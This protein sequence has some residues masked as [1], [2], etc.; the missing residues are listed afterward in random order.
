MEAGTNLAKLGL[1]VSN[2]VRIR[3][4][5]P[6]E[7][8][9]GEIRITDNQRKIVLAEPGKLQGTAEDEYYADYCYAEGE[10]ADLY[11]RSISP[12]V[13]SDAAGF[14]GFVDGVNCAILLFGNSRSGKTY[15][16]E[17]SGKGD[18]QDG[19]IPAVIHG[20]FEG[21][22]A[23]LNEQAQG[24]RFG[25]RG[26][27]R[28]WRH[29]LSMQ[30]IEVVNEQI[31]DLLNPQKLELEV[32]EQGVSEGLG[33]RNLTRKWID[34]EEEALHHFKV[35]QSGRTS[36]RGEFGPMSERATAVYCLELHQVTS[37]MH[38]GQDKPVEEHL[39]SRF[40][41]F[42][43]PGAETLADDPV[44]VRIREG[45]TL[46]NSVLGFGNVV[47]SLSQARDNLHDAEFVD[48]K[49]SVLTS[50]LPDVLGGNCRTSIVTTI[51]PA[52]YK[53]NSFTLQFAQLFRQLRNYPVVNDGRQVAL[54]RKVSNQ[55]HLMKQQIA[56]SKGRGLDVDSTFTDNLMEIHRLE[57]KII[58]D[59]NVR[60]ALLEE[61]EQL[62]ERVAQINARV[63]SLL[64]EK[65]QLQ[66]E[67]IASEE[68]KLK[69]SKVLVDLQIENA[70]L[71]EQAVDKE[72]QLENKLL[73]QENDIMELEMS[74]QS[75]QK[76]IDN[77][78]RQHASDLELIDD[79]KGEL[80]AV[81][82]NY[83]SVLNDL[84]AEKA[85]CEE[86]S[87]ELL[88]L[89]N[90]KGAL[91]RER[92][93][94]RTQRDNLLNM[95][96]ELETGLAQ[97]QQELKGS[98]GK[99]AEWQR[100]AE[101]SRTERDRA[102][103]DMDAARV[104]SKEEKLM[105][106]RKLAAIEQDKGQQVLALKSELA[107]RNSET[108]TLTQKF[109][110]DIAALR[111]RERQAARRAVELE[112]ELQVKAAREAQTQEEVRELREKLAKLSE[113]YRERLH[114]YISDVSHLSTEAARGGGGRVRARASQSSGAPWTP[115]STS[116]CRRTW[117]GSS[118]TTSSCT[119]RGSRRSRRSKR[120]AAS[121][122]FS[123]PA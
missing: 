77:L 35:G 49:Q 119:R 78:Q 88:N 59:E 27:S 29:K 8:R 79:M 116:S 118:R 70:S 3:P 105:G 63:Q 28:R 80:A 6:D 11:E 18:T 69:V 64:V 48:F 7:P 21:L 2:V 52:D 5:L 85:R 103:I 75:K 90:A 20:V 108:K 76:K 62:R 102:K 56:A 31:N 107:E 16:A 95:N 121:T 1:P 66:Q 82:S 24:G 91:V 61:R 54:A 72:F 34:S 42:D 40:L 12:L 50:L 96:A 47:K 37:I 25:A 4:L 81:R 57:K 110:D 87:I 92:D 43:L 30:Y 44:T 10:F 13:R 123:S 97:A 39:F 36:F 109:E 58:E 84:D 115:C 65:G 46:N 73:Q 113:D 55:V 94:V 71:L 68:E 41:I 9:A 111:G 38:P 45:A 53:A 22:Q 51:P 100:E 98:E 19:V 60:V 104:Q 14:P 83:A 112:D 15:T 86:L 120:T 67:R 93:Q 23:K 74:G 17:G 33:I 26:S 122:R 101:H 32:D 89:V 99:I 114:K 106:E 117:S